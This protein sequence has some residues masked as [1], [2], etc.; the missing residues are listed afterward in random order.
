MSKEQTAMVR[1]TDTNVQAGKVA[2]SSLSRPLS[3]DQVQ[4][5]AKTME[6]SELRM[7]IAERDGRKLMLLTKQELHD[8]VIDII[9]EIKL[10]T[11]C[12]IFEGKELQAQ[13]SVIRRFLYSSFGMLTK[14]EIIH[15]FYMNMEGKYNQ[16]YRHYNRELNAEFI[17][18]VLRSYLNY[19]LYLKETKGPGI[20]KLLQLGP[21]QV[22]KREVDYEF[23]KDLI[24]EEYEAFRKGESTL[25]MWH[26]RKYY[27]LRKFGLMPFTKGFKTWMYFFKKVMHGNTAG[28]NLPAGADIR[29]LYFGSVAECRKIFKND[30]DWKRCIDY[31]RRYA[32]WYML[33]ACQQCGINNLWNEISEK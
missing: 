19:K 8:T 24:Q 10:L 17:G 27:T 15:A 22:I 14:E 33:N 4:K 3:K 30:Q 23:W 7:I 9:S 6:T 26:Q 29:H 18:D 16:V 12:I 13:L 1:R 2:A 11:G 5:L 28:T 20:K 32:Y 25:Q 31:L 21:V